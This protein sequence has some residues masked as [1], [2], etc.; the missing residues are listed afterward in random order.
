MLHL[1]AKESIVFNNVI[2]TMNEFLTIKYQLSTDMYYHVFGR[3]LKV[4]SR[5]LRKGFTLIEL[6]IVVA[7]MSVLTV[8][9]ISTVN[10]MEQFKK[11]RD[12][13]RKASLAQIQRAIEAYYQDH[14]KYPDSSGDYRI[15]SIVEGTTSTLSWGDSWVPYMNVLPKDPK[16]PSRSFAYY[17]PAAANGQT[18][19]LYA[20]LERGKNDPQVCNGGDQ[21]TTLP[22]GSPCGDICNYGISSP[23]TKP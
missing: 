1:R 2:K 4:D 7:V 8:A 19:Y 16:S 11:S 3:R 18:Y 17:A 14:G 15:I 22:G 21:C 12:T 13:Q 10:P 6:I 5:K 9:L 23:N 20:S